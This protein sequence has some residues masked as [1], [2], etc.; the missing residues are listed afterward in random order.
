M[1]VS[2]IF[3]PPG[4]GKTTTLLNIVDSLMQRGIQPNQ[5]AFVSF[6]KKA[7]AEAVSRAA[8]KFDMDEKDFPYFRTLHSLSYQETRI[9]RHEVMSKANYR[10]L[11]DLLG[12]EFTG[13]YPIEEGLPTGNKEG[14]QL[15]FLDGLHRATGKDLEQILYETDAEFTIHQLR[16][17]CKTLRE[18]KNDSELLD[19]ADMLTK[20]VN[21]GEPIHAKVAI[22]DEAQDLSATQ[23]KVARTAFRN[24]EEVYIAGDDDQCIYQWSG[25]DISHFLS[26][27]GS[28]SVLGRSY[29]LPQRIYDVCVNISERINH[30]HD[31]QWQPRDEEGE[32]NPVYSA[33]DVDLKSGTW[34]LLAR[35]NYL[36]EDLTRVARDQGVAYTTKK[37]S[38]IDDKHLE[39]IRAWTAL[40]KNKFISVDTA[41]V[42]YDYMRVGV[43]FKRGA[44]MRLRSLASEQMLNLETLRSDYGLL[45]KG[46]WHDVLTGIGIEQREYYLSILRNGEK[47]TDKPRVHIST[48]HGVKG[49]EA[50]NVLL[51]PDMAGRT[52]AEMEKDADGEHR[53]FYVGASRASKRLYIAEPQSSYFYRI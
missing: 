28:D 20:F 52:F 8:V 26:I 13:Y 37:A 45:A 21:R 5:I 31:K 50:E 2:K 48:I 25:A 42:L 29:R 18:Y 53:V 24:C 14:D 27:K 9:R 35:N 46:I 32:V 7:A 38:S 33:D 51:L 11:A 36:L 30:R 19:Y 39:A 41:L 40:N 34:Y 17:F 47:L 16:H 49:G 12:V 4:T 22:I 44:K 23:W 15:L 43:G 6:T 3:G 10:E 1:Q